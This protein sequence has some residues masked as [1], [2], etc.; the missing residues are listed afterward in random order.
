[1]RAIWNHSQQ[2]GQKRYAIAAYL[3]LVQ[4]LFVAGLLGLWM[5]SAILRLI[6]LVSRKTTGGL[7]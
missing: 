1:M 7:G 4:L 2:S 6:T 5:S 3:P